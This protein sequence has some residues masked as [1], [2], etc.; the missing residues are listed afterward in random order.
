[1]KAD[2]DLDKSI[3]VKW[4]RAKCTQGQVRNLLDYKC[5]GGST[6]DR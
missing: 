5:V 4:E 3:I 1:M 2:G 6:S